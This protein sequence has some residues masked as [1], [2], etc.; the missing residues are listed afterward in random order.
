M[1]TMLLLFPGPGPMLSVNGSSQPPTSFV[2]AIAARR[3]WPHFHLLPDPQLVTGFLCTILPPRSL[4]VLTLQRGVDRKEVLAY[5]ENHGL[6]YQ[7]NEEPLDFGRPAGFALLSQLWGRRSADFQVLFRTA[8]RADLEWAV[9]RYGSLDRL[10][11]FAVAETEAEGVQERLAT[12]VSDRLYDTLLNQVDFIGLFDY[13]WEYFFC[14]S[15]RLPVTQLVNDFRS[16][17]RRGGGAAETV[18]DPD[19]LRKVVRQAEAML[20]RSVSN[21]RT[22]GCWLR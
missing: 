3:A 20:G 8:A 6:A 21:A 11:I 15:R 19:L 17:C 22:A 18:V 16:V 7:V 2:A 13:D 1:E 14:F 4:F 5:L 9:R 12:P 10:R